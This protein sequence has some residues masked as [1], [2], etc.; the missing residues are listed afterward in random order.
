MLM[1]AGL[2]NPAPASFRDPGG[3]LYRLPGRIVRAVESSHAT[4]L[5][6]FLNTDTARRA[7]AEGRLV[8]SARVSARDFPELN[9]PQD[10][11]SSL[12]EHERVW[13][14]TF[15]YEWPM[16]M[17]HSAA[18]LTLDLAE[19][20]L[21]EG[22]G[23]KD[24]SPYNVLFRGA[25]PVFVDLLSFERRDPL[26]AT[27]LAYGQF[28]R[29]FLLPLA[30]QRYFRLPIHQ[31]LATQRDGLEP[32]AVYAWAGWFRRLTP[33]L[34]G[35][36][37]L[38]KWLS[39]GGKNAVSYRPKAA[40]SVDQARFVLSRVLRSCRRQLHALKPRENA[41][42][43]WAGYLDHKSLYSPAQLEQKE[44]FVREAFELARPERVLDVGANEG[45]FSFLAARQG[46]EVV[47]IDTDST[48]TGSIFRRASLEKL[49]VLPLVADFARPT[50]AIGWRNQECPSFLER[51]A[52]QFDIV[53]FLAVLHHVL[54]TERIPL[55]DLLGLA[56]D[57]S[58]DFVLC[59]FV[60]PQDPMFRRIVRGRD[61]LYAHF[62]PAW[63]EAAA[64]ARFELVRS[65]KLDGLHRWL[66][67]F[68]RRRDAR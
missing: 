55:E 51:S 7:M 67:L 1:E 47:A 63:F 12:W 24:A 50:P 14:A 17:L 8:R 15:P 25:Q 28:V 27:W 45:H 16:E 62:S 48:V 9:L 37:S 39:A 53:M 40:R 11:A 22:F 23:L 34:L 35:L 49:N 68:R 6:A 21:E 64:T 60:A 61:E 33:P 5:E 29:T 58:R 66:Y 18:S 43:T 20:A 10:D 30:A 3:R 4:D 42:S 59:E 31:L 32:E 38:P 41:D 56:D 13:F 26:D 2:A 54:V 65:E 57:L 19:A 46:A 36:V 44:R 52:G